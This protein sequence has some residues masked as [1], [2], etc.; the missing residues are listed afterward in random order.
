MKKVIF[1]TWD[2]I[3]HDSGLVNEYYDRLHKNKIDY[4]EKI[5]AKFIL[6]YNTFNTEES[7]FVN[8]N[9]LKHKYMAELA[10][11]YDEVMYVDMDVVFNTDKNVFEELDLSKGIH[12]KD[13]DGEILDKNIEAL[14]LKHVGARSPTVK[15][16]ITKD[17]L[18]GKDN[19]VMNTGVMIGKSEHIKQIK[20][21][22]RL[23]SISEKIDEL[24]QDVTFLRRFYYPNNEAIF[25]YIMEEYNIPYMLMD[26]RWHHI[27]DHKPECIDLNDIEIAHFVNKKFNT[28]FKDKTKC[29][30]SLH[31]DIPDERLDNPPGPDDDPVNKSKRTK[32]RLSKYKERLYENHSNYAK[33]VGANYLHFNRDEQYEQFFKRFPDLSEYDVINL[34]KVYL[35][36][37]LTKEYDLVLYVDFDVYFNSN[38]D[39][40]N[41]LPAEVNFCCDT[42]TPRECG[43]DVKKIG[44]FENY[45][46]C[47]RNPETKYWNA[48]ALLQEED[49]NGDT[50][51]FNTGIMMA[52]RKVMEQINYFGDIDDVIETMTEL[53]EFSMYPPKIQKVFGYDNETIMAYKVKKN[54]VP[55]FKLDKCWHYK[56]NYNKL[57]AY[58]YGTPEYK[59]A[60]YEYEVA[61]KEHKVVMTHFIS[62][63]FGI[64]FDK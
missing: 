14:F 40:F 12:I 37:K 8:I 63:N 25:S 34:Y 11:L 23:K 31:I 15:Y 55:V 7:N 36:D 54:N 41:Y 38:I 42:A 27:I 56:H 28:F 2:D 1:T 57:P 24:K 35:L 44:Y 9:Y 16:H 60:K 10:E 48:H 49:I 30:Y 21:M 26:K 43:V 47:F 32:E 53:K 50:V 22:N 64:V 20:F 18:N 29:I 39:A 13:E 62:K 51:V 61:T 45:D 59:K 17:L 46:K 19:H 33:S 5:G 4:A 3:N 52:S 6:F 58:T